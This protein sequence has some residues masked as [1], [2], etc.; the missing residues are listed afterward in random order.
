MWR[1]VWDVV[2]RDI[3]PLIDILEP[4]VPPEGIAE[5]LGTAEHGAAWQSGSEALDH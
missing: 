1:D 5:E 4:L 2:V 3:P